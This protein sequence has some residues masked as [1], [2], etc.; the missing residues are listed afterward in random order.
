MDKDHYGSHK[1]AHV[2]EERRFLLKR[3][4]EDLDHPYV[5]IID[6]YISGTRLR[7]R[8]IED[9]SGAVLALKLGQK[10]RAADQAT[11]HTTMTT[12]YLNDSE[13]EVLSR[14]NGS[15]LIKRRYAYPYG[16][17]AYSIDVF[18]GHLNGLILA[19]IQSQ[20]GRTVASLPMPAFARREVTG[21][22]FFTGGNLA[23]VSADELFQYLDAR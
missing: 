22:Q 8:R 14:L 12:I 20:Q 13:Y 2:E 1:Y 18:A 3:V 9:A 5:K 17:Y 15:K 7:L 16:G 11:L 6:R 4:L 10:Y 21:E 23:T 19:E